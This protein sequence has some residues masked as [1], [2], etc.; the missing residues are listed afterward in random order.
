M[1]HYIVIQT[2]WDTD[3]AETFILGCKHDLDAA[4]AIFKTEQAELR[5]KQ[6]RLG[7]EV[8]SDTETEYV[9]GNREYNIQLYIEYVED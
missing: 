8:Y 4:Q 3:F 1:W 5:K 6:E 9:I 2:Y 7:W